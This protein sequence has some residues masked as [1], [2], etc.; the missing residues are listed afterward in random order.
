MSSLFYTWF[1]SVIATLDAEYLRLAPAVRFVV[2]HRRDV[3]VMIGLV[4][5]HGLFYSGILPIQP[6]SSL[7]PKAIPVKQPFWQRKTL[8]Q[9]NKKEWESLCDGC[10]RCCLNKY[11]EDSGEIFYTDVACKLLDT[12]SCRCSNYQKRQKLVPDCISLTPETLPEMSCLPPTCGYRL[13]QEGKN[14]SWWHPLVSGR[15]A[16][17]H[18]A[19]I[20][21]RGRVVSEQGLSEAE[22][23]LRLVRWPQTKTAMK[24]PKGGVKS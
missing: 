19:G 20:S 4:S 10:G 9:L 11:E 15:A 24:R 8:A 23:E 21:V 6:W 7:L 18:E 22:I 1:Y 13:V 17:V 5:V 3:G 14:L 16:T 12:E 2:H